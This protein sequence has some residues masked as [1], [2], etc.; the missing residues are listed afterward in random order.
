[1]IDKREQILYGT[2]NHFRVICR[3]VQMWHAAMF[4]RIAHDG[5]IATDETERVFHGSIVS[6][7][8]N[9]NSLGR[10]HVGGSH[11]HDPATC[12]DC[13]EPV[14]REKGSQYPSKS[15]ARVKVSP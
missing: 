11:H 1:M 15:A 9:L 13:S 6:D 12:P 7:D 4:R 10:L 3:E 5:Y 8:A 14:P 2:T